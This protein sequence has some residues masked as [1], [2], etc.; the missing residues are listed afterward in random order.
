MQPC[1]GPAFSVC[2]AYTPRVPGGK[3]GQPTRSHFNAI[4]ALAVAPASQPWQLGHSPAVRAGADR[5][6]LIAATVDAAQMEVL[7]MSKGGFSISAAHAGRPQRAMYLEGALGTCVQTLAGHY[8]LCCMRLCQ[9]RSRLPGH[10][11]DANAQCT[12]GWKHS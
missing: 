5:A 6:D 1:V 3:K 10:P 9:Y 4:D 2:Q 7:I 8:T 11:K 12:T